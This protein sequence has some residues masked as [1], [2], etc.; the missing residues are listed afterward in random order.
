MTGNRSLLSKVSSKHDSL[1]V[2]LGDNGKY[3]VKDKGMRTAFMEGKVLMW[4]KDSSIDEAIVIGTR[5]N[6]LYKL[7]GHQAQALVH[8]AD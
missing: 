2:E 1:Q 7:A 5:I 4:P 6:G 3:Q 8:E